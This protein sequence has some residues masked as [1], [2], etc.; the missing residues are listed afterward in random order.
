M[1]RLLLVCVLTFSVVASFAQRYA[2]A[3]GA[4]SGAIWA[5]TPNGAAGSASVPTA[6]DDVYTNGFLITVSTNQSCRN[7]F[8]T[9]NLANSL[10][11]NSLRSLTVTG[12]LN[13]YDD[14]NKIEEIPTAAVLSFA[15][16]SSIVF[17]AANIQPAYDP[18]VIF[19][20]DNTIPLGRVTFNLGGLSKNIIIPLSISA[21]M[22]LQSGT[23]TADPGSDLSGSSTATLQIDAGAT[24]ITNDPLANF[25]NFQISGTVQ[26]SSSI[27]AA[28]AAGTLTV[29]SGGVVNST[30]A[31]SPIT[32]NSITIS[33]TVTTS[34]ALNVSGTFQINSGGILNTS[35]AGSQGWWSTSAPSSLSLAANST[36]NY[37]G[38][39]QNVASISYGNL[40]LSGSGTKSVSGGG[41]VNVAGN[42][43]FGNAG[44][45]LTSS[46]Q[47]IFNGLAAQS[48]SGGG[49]ANFNGG[50]QINKTGTL[51]LS[52]NISVQNGLTITSGTFDL[53]SNTVNLSGNLSNSGTL[54]A[55]ASTL[56][57][58]GSSTFSGAALT[59]NNLTISGSGSLTAPA[60]LNIT[61]NFTNNGTFNANGG[62]LLFNG[63][64]PQ[65]IG[66]ST[67]TN[68]YDVT[69]SN[70]VSLTSPQN[71]TGILTVSSNTLTTN[72]NLTLISNA[73]S[74]AMIG[75]S[76]GT[77]SGNV[78]V[79]KY[80]NNSVK[81][82]R[83]LASPVVGAT[84]A[85]WKG[86]F[87]I[88]GT[89]NDPSTQSEW[90][91]I[92]GI[93]QTAPSMYSYNEPAGGA[94]GARFASFPPNGSSTGAAT[95]TNGT[96]YAA[97]IRQTTPI[98]LAVNGTVRQGTNVQ[99]TLTNTNGDA[100]DDGWNL[101]GNPFPAPISWS[102]V[103][104]PPNVSATMS[105]KD[106]NGILVTPGNY[107]TCTGGTCIP[108]SYNGVIPIGQAFW[109]RRTA[110]GS[111]PITFGESN[112]AATR[113]PT[114]LRSETVP[115]LLR[116][117]LSGNGR[118]DELIVRLAVGA[119]DASDNKFDGF[120]LNNDFLN[121]Y[122]L[123]TDGQKMA[124][125][126]AE[127]LTTERS[128]KNFPLRIEGNGNWVIAPGAYRISVTEIE[129]FDNG[130]EV[131][132]KD[133][134]LRDSVLV[135]QNF[136][137]N[138]STVADQ[139]SYKDR[140][141]LV[142]GR[143]SVTTSTLDDPALGFTKVYPN[144]TNGVF[145]IET[146]QS[147]DKAVT[148]LNSI[149]QQ[150]GKVDLTSSGQ[151]L[152]GTCDLIAQPEGVY[153]VQI[154]NGKKVQTKKIVKK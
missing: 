47:L 2:R 64:V 13:G 114:F 19:F 116:A 130:I 150:I 42:L 81:S 95:L 33:G 83:Y 125:N 88:T 99:I 57:I 1:K 36:I 85:A 74:D 98:T 102:T 115:N 22:R 29:N 46:N 139:K 3:N 54:T 146:E 14:V 80:F 50:L 101:I 30:G 143:P 23:L 132:L 110:V 35:F 26:T 18:Y 86:S 38:S 109:V 138:F 152:V 68:F 77:V 135:T 79:Q 11:I 66:G 91:S 49:T 21:I 70:A 93:V 151:W 25:N 133:G 34:N 37:S 149:G 65:T 82:Y 69:T 96:G 118:E 48:I 27:S 92:P 63:S 32:A 87:P 120:K 126:G 51:T 75:N 12:T 31:A 71:L 10:T 136:E 61:G 129:S 44:I 58:T 123:S 15:S 145:T 73:S 105:L 94:L 148:I 6:T 16:R 90:P 104:I 121:F 127:P 137:Y 59:L 4:W 100:T 72:N 52:Q 144:P 7:L 45:S 128:M 17:T 117:K 41:S 28:G 112:K 134:Y 97:F 111:G 24:L 107:V 53:G 124:I 89:F 153:F 140:F 142:I 56:N 67:V 76:A 40:T 62:T 103:T 60:T 20:W 55:S 108:G 131:Y 39:S 113:N 106:N 147:A 78:T 8:I 84:A 5:S 141:T 122:S 119:S 43:L 154:V 9:F